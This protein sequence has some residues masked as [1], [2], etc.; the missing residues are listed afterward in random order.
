MD[1]NFIFLPNLKKEEK[2]KDKMK[3]EER[4]FWKFGKV[5]SW[6]PDKITLDGIRKEW[7][8]ASKMMVV[9]NEVETWNVVQK[10]GKDY[11]KK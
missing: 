4:K 5:K 11:S 7:G 6:R 2:V 8:I 3:F 9:N 10:S 1:K